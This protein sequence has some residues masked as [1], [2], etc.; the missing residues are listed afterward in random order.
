MRAHINVKGRSMKLRHFL[1]ALAAVVVL[2]V[3]TPTAQSNASHEKL[4]ILHSLSDTMS[5]VDVATNKVIKTVEVGKHPHGISTPRSRTL[6]YVSTEGDGGLTVVDTSR[7][8][9]VKKYGGMG[10]RPQEGDITPDGRFLYLPSYAG[11]WQV[12]DTQKEEI[13]ERIFTKGLGHNTLISPDGRLAYLFPIAPGPGH[14]KLGLG[15]PTTQPRE[16]TV[17]DTT[18]HKVVGTIPLENASRPPAF[19]TDGKRIFSQTDNLLGFVVIDVASRRVV[20]KATYTLTP[21]EQAVRSRS[22]GIAALA[23]GKEVWSNDVNHNLTFVFD[24]TVDPPKQI[25]RLDLGVSPYWIAS[26]KDGK[27]VYV[28]SPPD[29]VVIAFDA[30]TK[31]EKARISLPGKGPKRIIVVDTPRPVQ[32]TSVR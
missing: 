4:Y 21:D 31:T 30:V 11:Y 8:E 17:V 3:S 1:L 23:G 26:S 5:V 6:L 32:A 7:D 10:L 15:L 12:F 22:H 27:T 29:H 20:S 24:V 25:A 19:S 18:T 13:I 14:W 16:V 28:S 2:V 9:V